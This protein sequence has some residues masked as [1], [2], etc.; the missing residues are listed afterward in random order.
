MVHACTAIRLACRSAASSNANVSA[1][2]HPV[3]DADRDRG[4]TGSLS[5]LMTATGQ[6]AWVA[7]Y[8]LTDPSSSAPN[9][10]PPRDPT[11][12]ISAPAPLSATASAG[13]PSSLSVSISRPGA[14]AAA[15]SAALVSALSRYDAPGISLRVVAGHG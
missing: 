1:A 2:P 14:V 13:W 8:L 5:A 15:C 4:R 7:T 9:A 10:P 6:G 11:T 3:A 12:S